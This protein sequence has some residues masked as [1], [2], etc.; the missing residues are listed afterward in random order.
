MED[1]EDYWSEIFKLKNDVGVL[2]FPNLK[3]TFSLLL[4]LPY[5]NA[6]VERIFSDLF[7]IKTEKRNLLKTSNIKAI[8]ATKEGVMQSSGCMKFQ[9][10][11]KNVRVQNMTEH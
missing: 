11:K 10:T 4:V 1:A 3:K 9:P 5:S 6:S 8:L 7:N 2:F